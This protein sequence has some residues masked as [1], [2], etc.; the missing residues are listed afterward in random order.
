MKE[1]RK[2][3]KGLTGVVEGIARAKAMFPADTEVSRNYLLSQL[4]IFKLLFIFK[5]RHHWTP[6]PLPHPLL[7][8]KLAA[9]RHRFL[10]L[11]PH[12][13]QLAATG[14]ALLPIRQR[15]L[16]A[17]GH[18][19]LRLLI[20]FHLRRPLAA[21]GLGFLSSPPKNPNPHPPPFISV[22]LLCKK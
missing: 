17:A 7:Q 9:D 15:K 6:L 16:D 12:G 20:L 3:I 11:F 19:P 4:L 13:Q 18:L 21:T 14:Q 2:E 22:Y 1:T 5:L 8:R 10:Q